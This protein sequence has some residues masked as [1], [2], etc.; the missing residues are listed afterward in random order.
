MAL[1]YWTEEEIRR[2]KERGAAMSAAL[3]A[4]ERGCLHGCLC[5]LCGGDPAKQQTP[6]PD[7]KG[8]EQ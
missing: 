2:A 6:S 8:S 4:G 5:A 7:Q 1:R 3:K